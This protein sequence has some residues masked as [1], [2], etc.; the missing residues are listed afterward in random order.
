M[1]ITFVRRRWS[2][3]GGAENYLQRLAARLGKNGHEVDLVCEEWREA[4][5]IFQNIHSLPQKGPRAT[6]PREFARTANRFLSNHPTDCVFSLERGIACDIYR[7]GDG[8]HRQWLAQRARFKP[9]LGHLQNFL[10]PKN[11]ILCL[12]ESGTFDPEITSHVIANSEMV[13]KDILQ[14]FSFP[15]DRISV[16]HNG[17]DFEFFSSGSRDNGRK[18]LGI[19]KDEFILLLVGAGAER[20]GIKYAQQTASRVKGSRLLIIDKTPP[21]P[22]PD[23]YAAADVF[24]FPTL[25]DPFANVTLEAMAAGLPVITTES[26]GGHEAIQSGKNGFIALAADQVDEMAA[27]CMAMMDSQLR[28]KIGEE[29]RAAARL[30]S[31]EKNVSETLDL[32]GRVL[33]KSKAS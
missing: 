22:M 9:L 15:E 13:K 10:N 17:V 21:C 3:T 27:Y 29:A 30:F 4:P 26:N 11:N 20:K 2:P 23:V 14:W 16:I 33:E 25:Y 18:A 19:S 31:L 8:V 32:C 7:A 24:L 12:L 5:D 28:M 6:R 1:K